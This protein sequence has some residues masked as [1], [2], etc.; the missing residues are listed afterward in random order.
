[1]IPEHHQY[2]WNAW[3]DLCHDRTVGFGYTGPILFTAIDAYAA[4][5]GITDPDEFADF[6]ALMREVD[7]VYLAELRKRQPQ[8]SK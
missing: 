4:R 2:L 8:G 6:L 1:V 5:I 3:R 7:A